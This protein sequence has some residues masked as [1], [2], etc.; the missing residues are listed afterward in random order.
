ML[1]TVRITFLFG[2]VGS[3]PGFKDVL[4]DA[5]LPLLSLLLGGA[6]SRDLK[7]ISMVF[8]NFD[9]AFLNPLEHIQHLNCL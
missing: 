6:G 7:S 3:T 4:R 2:H 5:N 8:E 1:N 9:L